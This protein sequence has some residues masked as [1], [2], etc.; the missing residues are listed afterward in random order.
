MQL[1]SLTRFAWLSIAAAIATM[2]LKTAAYY[3]TGSVGLLSDA[4]ESLVNLAGEALGLDYV[5]IARLLPGATRVEIH[6][7]WL[8]GAPAPAGA[9]D[10][11]NTPCAEPPLATG[12]TGTSYDD[13]SP[14]LGTT[15]YYYS[16]KAVNACGAGECS[17][18]DPG[19][20]GGAPVD[21]DLDCDV[22]AEDIEHVRVRR[23][24]VLGQFGV[25]H[26]L[27]HAQRL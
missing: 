26:L 4:L 9:Y 14:D 1:P 20:R 7:A 2:A 6:A 3:F 24:N 12:V 15:Q 25:E 17:L 16:V 22:D 19:R 5:H 18:T 21:F 27:S 8:D 23:R 13:T 10:L 11:A